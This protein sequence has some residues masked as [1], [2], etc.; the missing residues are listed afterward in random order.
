MQTESNKFNRERHICWRQKE[1][2]YILIAAAAENM[3][4]HTLDQT[5]FQTTFNMQHA[6]GA[7]IC[8]LCLPRCGDATIK[9]RAATPLVIYVSYYFKFKMAQQFFFAFAILYI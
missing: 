6:H 2:W 4:Q 9:V 8:G 3:V 5:C 7:R 1:W